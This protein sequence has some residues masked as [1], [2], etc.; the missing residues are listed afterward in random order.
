M[1]WFSYQKNFQIHQTQVPVMKTAILLI[2]AFVPM[3]LSMD[4]QHHAK[5]I[6]RKGQVW[7]EIKFY[8][9]FA[10]ISEV[11]EGKR[12]EYTYWE[13]YPHERINQYG[14]IISIDEFCQLFQLVNF[15]I[16]LDDPTPSIISI[17]LVDEVKCLVSD[18]YG[19]SKSDECV[20]FKNAVS[21]F[22]DN[23]MMGN[24]TADQRR[25]FL[26]LRTDLYRKKD[27]LREKNKEVW[28]RRS[29]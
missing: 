7:Q 16:F 23:I 12:V 9:G 10:S 1:N 11:Y 29:F 26:K 18:I 14:R 19:D 28:N 24:A 2:I 25:Q 4:A 8:N 6:P 17:E 21:Q 3:I 15:N 22:L 20:A 13:I 27:Q 5:E